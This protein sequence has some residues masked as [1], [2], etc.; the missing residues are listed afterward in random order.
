MY[1]VLYVD[2][3]LYV[4]GTYI[5]HTYYSEYRRVRV[6]VQLVRVWIVALRNLGNALLSMERNPC[7]LKVPAAQTFGNDAP[8][9]LTRLQCARDMSNK[10]HSPMCL[11]ARA[12]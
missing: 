10:V 7:P 3:K 12:L 11:A 1:Y 5:I 6:I 4:L 9:M 8:S 2:R